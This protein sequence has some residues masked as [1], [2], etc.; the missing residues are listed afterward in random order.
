[1][2][3]PSALQEARGKVSGDREFTSD[4]ADMRAV[5]P[6]IAELIVGYPQ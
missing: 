6:T 3:D 4:N 5:R 1:V 2:P